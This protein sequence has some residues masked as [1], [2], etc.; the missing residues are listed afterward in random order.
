LRACAG[1]VDGAL[2]EVDAGDVRPTAG[3]PGGVQPG[4]A[5]EVG[6]LRSFAHSQVGDDPFHGAIDERSA[7]GGELDLLVEV[8]G[9]HLRGGVLIGPQLVGGVELERPRSMVNRFELVEH[10]PKISHRGRRVNRRTGLLSCRLHSVI[11]QASESS[12]RRAYLL[13]C[14]W[15]RSVNRARTFP[16]SVTPPV[17]GSL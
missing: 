16:A 10:G 2:R 12:S 8:V 11:P 17:G 7:A 15:D 13:D 14:L 5:A 6:D 9:Q 1:V 3:Q 4:P